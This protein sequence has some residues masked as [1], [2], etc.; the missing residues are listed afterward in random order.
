MSD[1]VAKTIAC[2]IVASRFDYC[3]ALLYRAPVAI[4]NKLQR[5]QNNLARVVCQCRG[6]SDARPLLRPLT[7]QRIKYK[8]ALITYRC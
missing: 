1:D 5:A 4:I 3:N 2:N 8:I 7:S 6:R